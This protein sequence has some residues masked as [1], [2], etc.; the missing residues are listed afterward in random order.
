MEN[1]NIVLRAAVF[2]A[3]LIIAEQPK[4]RVFHNLHHT[5]T[6]LEGAGRIGRAENLTEDELE[7]VLLAAVFHDLGHIKCYN[8][9]EEV[10]MRFARKWLSEHQYPEDKT[11]IV[12][13]CIGATKIPQSPK[14]ILE[15]VV[16]DA[17]LIHLSFE[18]YPIY[19]EMLRSEWEM[20]LGL[21]YSD[22][23]W[24]ANNNK[25]LQD[26]SYFTAYGKNVLEPKK[27]KIS[28]IYR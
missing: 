6:V 24:I 8:G 20:E 28:N 27:V 11:T 19:R 26:H 18:S 10:S 2:A 9:H 5:L 7:M 13:G 4:N 17:D 25:F 21:T 14:H 22:E 23:E 1:Q 3:Q 15:Q 16:C 12:L